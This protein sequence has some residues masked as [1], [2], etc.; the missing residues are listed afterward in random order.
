[1]RGCAELLRSGDVGKERGVWTPYPRGSPPLYPRPFF[2][3]LPPP[4]FFPHFFWGGYPRP[5]SDFLPPH[6]SQRR[7]ADFDIPAPLRYRGYVQIFAER[8]PA[9]FQFVDDKDGLELGIG[10]ICCGAD[11]AP[12]PLSLRDRVC[13]NACQFSAYL[14]PRPLRACVNVSKWIKGR[15]H[16]RFQNS[17]MHPHKLA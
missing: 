9:D 16:P 6:F 3:S 15:C 13:V 5:N 11:F 2:S 4:P 1:M 14:R 17:S 7:R 10:P 8:M 12:A